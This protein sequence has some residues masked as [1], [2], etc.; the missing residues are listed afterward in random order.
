MKVN[1]QK[2]TAILLSFFISLSFLNISVYADTSHGGADT[3]GGGS[4]GSREVSTVSQL[5]RAISTETEKLKNG[6]IDILEYQNNVSDIQNQFYINNTVGDNFTSDVL[7]SAYDKVTDFSEN[8]QRAAIQYGVDAA[9]YVSDKWQ[10]ICL[11]FNVPTKTTQISTEKYPSGGGAGYIIINSDG[12]LSKFYCDYIVISSDREIFTLYS[13]EGTKTFTIYENDG[14]GWY[15]TYS[16]IGVDDQGY[17]RRWF[18]QQ[19]QYGP[20]Q[21]FGDI[22]YDDGSRAPTD[23]E[24]ITTIENDIDNVPDRDIVDMLNDLFDRLKADFPDLSSIEGLLSAILARMSKLD[25]DNDNALL[26]QVLA[27]INS[28]K[29]SQDKN[30]SDLLD[31]L[32]QI[33]DSLVFDDEENKDD[34]SDKLKDYIE[35]S[36][37]LK[38]FVIDEDLYNNQLEVLKNRILGKFSFIHNM[39]QFILYCFK[40]YQNTEATP[41]IEFN[42]N[43]RIYCIDFSF[44]NGKIQLFQFLI[45]AFIYASYAIHT[46]RKIPSYINGGDNE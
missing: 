11:N 10:E 34:L 1:L 9:K 31:L 6:T 37:T 30:N 23:D 2:A 12:S 28:L 35:N 3:G 29:S 27:A 13:N 4:G 17:T 39:K 18:S 5:Y 21:F 33:K 38:D 20:L 42:Y 14:N 36:L 19:E 26:S 44:W 41:E 16:A 7:K 40:Q 43:G 8:V 24:Y 32:D 45:A 25:S 46:Y 15:E 22:R